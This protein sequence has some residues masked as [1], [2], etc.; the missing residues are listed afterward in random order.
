MHFF[1]KAVI[2][3]V[4]LIIVS[5]NICRFVNLDQSPAGFHVDE[6]SSAVTVQCVDQEGTDALGN[7]CPFVMPPV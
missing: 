5:V 4:W 1:R 7:P 6:L 2:V 3:W